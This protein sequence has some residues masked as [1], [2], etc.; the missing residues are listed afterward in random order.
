M[1]AA[2]MLIAWSAR[3]DEL[4]A[5]ADRLLVNRRDVWGAYRPIHLRDSGSR[6]Y[7]APARHE[8]GVRLLSSDTLRR[9]FHCGDDGSVIG[10]HSTSTD[11][12]SRWLGIDLDNHGGGDD[13]RERNNQTMTTL[14]RGLRGR[15]AAP[16]VEDS[17]GR[18]GLHLWVVFDAPV[19]TRDVYA[20]AQSV[21]RE[22]NV[23]SETFPKQAVV[24]PGG[25][26]NW[27]RLPGRHH[28]RQHWSRVM[29]D[30][31]WLDGADAVSALLSCAITPGAI[32][33]AAAP[34]DVL[35]S[36]HSLFLPNVILDGDEIGRRAAAY[37]TRV[38]SGLAAG[39]GRNN[40]AFGVA[41]FL[42]RD[43]A[44]DDMAALRWLSMWN[45]DNRPPLDER[46]LRLVLASARRCGRRAVGSGLHR[47]T[48]VPRWS[49]RPCGGTLMA[50]GAVR[51]LARRA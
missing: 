25:Y 21:L 49:V 39:E 31:G 3:A 24:A 19:P 32:V 26:G 46:E 18:G 13:E 1:N 42:V 40:V 7:T 2:S 22:G 44:L 16:L 9:H 36:E 4:A 20:F 43:L 27:L 14:L 34:T 29:C 23:E 47:A 30:D 6:T 51:P 28:T 17:D 35:P 48:Q 33:P 45:G 11:G 38:P 10:L 37:L 12:M 15:G 50:S 5:W 41:C 8:R